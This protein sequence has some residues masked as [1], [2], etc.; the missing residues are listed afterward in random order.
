MAERRTINDAL[1]LPPEKVAFIHGDQNA[2]QALPAAPAKVPAAATAADETPAARSD[3]P[4][5]PKRSKRVGR[6]RRRQPQPAPTSSP[7]GLVAQ[8]RVPLTTRLHPDTAEALRR[9]CLEQKLSGKLP[10]TQQD[11][12]EQATQAWLRE[13][14]FLKAVP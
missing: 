2:A 9:A 1:T 5:E 7:T 6:S 14:G 11:I 13:Y 12:V 4:S 8:L 10:N 3:P